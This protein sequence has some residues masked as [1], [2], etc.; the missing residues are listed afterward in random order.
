VKK[1]IG[2]HLKTALS[3][4]EFSIIFAKQTEDLWKVNVEFK[5]KKFGAA[6]LI[7]TALFGIDAITGEVKE[8]QKGN[9]WRF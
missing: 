2:E 1:K 9:Y 3:V 7:T 8:F 4:E 6:E 5:E